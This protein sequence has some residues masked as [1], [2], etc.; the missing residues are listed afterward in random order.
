ML[1]FRTS[2]AKYDKSLDTNIRIGTSLN[3]IK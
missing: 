1:T 3:K 2:V